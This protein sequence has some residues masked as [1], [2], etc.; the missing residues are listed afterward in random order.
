MPEPADV[1]PRLPGRHAATADCADRDLPVPAGSAPTALSAPG[2]PCSACGATNAV[3]LN[4]CA[5]CGLG[6]L[7]GLQSAAEPL[8]TLPGVG[9][10]GAL[11][12]A[13]RLGLAGGVVLVVVLLTLLVGMLF[14]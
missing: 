6:F 14:G 12:R 5:G 10:V 1:G 11:S 13:Q 3:E 9:D 2:W 8:L 7:A 4:A